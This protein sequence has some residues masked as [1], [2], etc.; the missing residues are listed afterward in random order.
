MILVGSD[1]QVSR[2]WHWGKGNLHISYKG[3]SDK[4]LLSIF[5][6][7]FS[8]IGTRPEGISWKNDSELS[9]PRT[10]P[11]LYVRWRY[12]TRTAAELVPPQTFFYMRS[13]IWSSYTRRVLSHFHELCKFIQVDLCLQL[14]IPKDTIH[15]SILPHED[16]WRRWGLVVDVS[17]EILKFL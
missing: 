17:M 6:S 9:W 10:Y 14:S 3:K 4:M 15:A 11:S 13:S 2:R 8:G 12:S 16:N 7:H 5:R 1:S